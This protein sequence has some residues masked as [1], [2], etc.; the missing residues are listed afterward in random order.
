MIQAAN[1]E[2]AT[3]T[4]SRARK[5]K[6]QYLGRQRR[7]L[8]RGNGFG[9]WYLRFKLDGR[10]IWRSLETTEN[11][12]AIVTAK[13]IIDAE[14]NA[15]KTGVRDQARAL[16]ARPGYALLSKVC[17][18]F[19][20]NF[21]T[22]ATRR[23]SASHYVGSLK[24]LVRLG[25]PDVAWEEAR[26]DLLTGELIRKYEAA[27]V[28]GIVRVKHGFMDQRSE[29]RVRRT[30]QSDLKQARS[31]FRRGIM[32]WY[33]GLA[34]PDVTS[35]RD[36]GITNPRRMKPERLDESMVQSLIAA[37]PALASENPALYICF[38]LFSRLGLRNSEQKVARMSWIRRD[39]QGRGFLEIKDRPDENVRTKGT[40]A[41]TLTIGADLLAEIDMHWSPSPDGDF[42]I[43][44]RNLTHRDDIVDVDHSNWCGQWIKDRSKTSYELR[45][46]AGSI[47][48]KKTEQLAVVQAFLGHSDLE[49]TQRWYLYLLADM[50]AVNLGD[51]EL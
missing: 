45:R 6:F 31:I 43:P 1:G 37:A 38:L 34:F 33:E 10:S 16:K 28:A 30:V 29:L 48:Y 19:K 13:K 17:E 27:M 8:K 20:S 23:A 2:A 36:Q 50:P 39:A 44:A 40:Q 24:K 7:L 42:I 5:V 25:A 49:T 22:S 46:Y 26:T 32:S 21:A 41:R 4:Q 9:P 18:I 51:F 14:V 3:P 11:A 47:L 35:F 15:D 12:A